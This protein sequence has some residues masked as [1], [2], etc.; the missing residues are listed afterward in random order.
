MAA[1]GINVFNEYSLPKA[2][3][4]FRQGFGRLIRSKTDFGAVVV[5]DPR[6]RTRRYGPKFLRSI[7]KCFQVSSLNELKAFFDCRKE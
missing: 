3:V 1:R 4:K 2:V 6:I 5:L 7:P